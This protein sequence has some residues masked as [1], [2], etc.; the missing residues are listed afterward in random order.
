MERWADLVYAGFK[1]MAG[2]AFRKDL[3]ALRRISG[4]AG[5]SRRRG[6][7]QDCGQEGKCGHEGE[8][9]LAHQVLLPLAVFSM[10]GLSICLSHRS[11]ARRPMPT[12]RSER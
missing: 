6:F 5:G 1:G 12:R 3:L 10:P 7:N 8:I 2:L 4:S 9:R 11:S